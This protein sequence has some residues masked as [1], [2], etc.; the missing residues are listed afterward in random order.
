MIEEPE[1]IMHSILI[2]KLQMMKICSVVLIVFIAFL[3]VY[4]VWVILDEMQRK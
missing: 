4:L 3:I 1:K 2:L